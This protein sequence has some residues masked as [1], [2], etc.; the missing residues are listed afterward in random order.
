M[1]NGKYYLYDHILPDFLYSIVYLYSNN[2]NIESKIFKVFVKYF[3]NSNIFEFKF[4]KENFRKDIIVTCNLLNNYTDSAYKVYTQLCAEI[5]FGDIFLNSFNYPELKELID[6]YLTKDILHI[7][8]DKYSFAYIAYKE[9]NWYT[10][11]LSEGS[12]ET[13]KEAYLDMQKTIIDF[14]EYS[15]LEFIFFNCLNF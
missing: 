4:C 11:P 7:I 3:E 5:I 1:N 2:I 10:C 13:E 14:C 15:N 8:C 6:R 9:N 12:F